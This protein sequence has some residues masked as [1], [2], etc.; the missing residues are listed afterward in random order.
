MKLT[1]AMNLAIA[2]CLP[3]KVINAIGSWLSW[4]EKCSY[5]KFIDAQY[6]WLLG[7]KYPTYESQ[8]RDIQVVLSVQNFAFAK[9]SHTPCPWLKSMNKIADAIF[10]NA[11]T[12]QPTC[13]RNRPIARFLPAK[14]FNATS[15]SIPSF[16]NCSYGKL[17]H[18]HCNQ[19]VG[20]QHSTC[21]ATPR[22]SYKFCFQFTTL[23]LRN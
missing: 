1:S 23:H 6:N 14:V 11:H 10:N 15:N 5:A 2:Q 22:I 18:A 20:W 13:A 12:V 16:K 4:L 21:D 8:R 17:I 9:P 19:P 7:W 3:T